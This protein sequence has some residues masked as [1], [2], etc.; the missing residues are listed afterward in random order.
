MSCLPRPR[1][2]A[3]LPQFRRVTLNPRRRPQ[4]RASMRRR[5][6]RRPIRARTSTSTPAATG[7]R[8]IPFLPTRCAGR[9]RSRCS[10]ERNRYLL[11]QELDAAAKDPKTPLQKKY[12]DYYAACMNTGLDREEG[13]GAAQARVEAHCGAQGREEPGPH[14]GRTGRRGHPAPLFRFGVQQDEKDSSKQIASI[15]RAAFRCRIATTTSWT[16]TLPDHPPAISSST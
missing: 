6:T 5:S 8:A 12:G 4:P 9:G 11:W 7:S 14:G 3:V 1:V 13:T 2:V 16:T 15:A 10:Q